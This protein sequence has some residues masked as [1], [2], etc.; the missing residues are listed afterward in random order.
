M[1]VGASRPQSAERA[2]VARLRTPPASRS[3]VDRSRTVDKLQLDRV[4]VQLA[5]IQRVA[6]ERAAGRNPGGRCYEAVWGHISAAGY[7]KMPGADIPGSHSEYAKQFAYYADKH[8]DE[9]G[10][11]K[12]PL[13][14]PYDAPPGA[15]VV[16]NPGTPGTSHPVAG[17]IALAMGGGRFLNDGEMGYGG[18]GNF[19]PGNSH[20]LGIYVP[21]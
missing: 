15:L 21:A 8:L 7:G 16:V 2:T 12:L 3:G 10:L 20:V 6:A 9:L 14:N 1:D 18:P 19:P 11:E 4:A 13:D 17:D 5:A